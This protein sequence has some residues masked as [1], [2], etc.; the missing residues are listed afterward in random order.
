MAVKYADIPR[1]YVATFNRVKA[2]AYV[3]VAVRQ[4]IDGSLDDEPDIDVVVFA[5]D[6]AT[7]ERF[8]EKANLGLPMTKFYNVALAESTMMNLVPVTEFKGPAEEEDW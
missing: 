4:L 6:Q 3:G 5:K 2:P 1:A 7:L 8:K